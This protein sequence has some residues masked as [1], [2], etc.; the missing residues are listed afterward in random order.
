MGKAGRKELYVGVDVGGTKILAA[1][2]KHNGR[3]VARERIPT[4]LEAKPAVVVKAI[5]GAV[6]ALSAKAGVARSD[7][8][9]IG[10]AIPGVVDPDAGRVVIT[11]NMNL[12]GVRIVKAV[13]KR[14]DVPVALGN[15]VN[16]GTLGEKWL[17]AARQA[18]SVVGIF[19]GT[20]IGG[21]V[22]LDGRLHRGFRDSAGEVGHLIM[23]I[24]GPQCGCGARGCFE[25]IASRT[26]IER[27]IR[28]AIASRRR[29]LVSRLVDLND[30]SSLI[31][32]G[33]LRQALARKDK[34][35]LEVLHRAAE[36][37]GYA[38]LSIR[39]LIDPEVIVF[40]GGVIEACGYFLLPII[41]EIVTSDPLTGARPGGRIVESALADDAVA[42]GAAA[43]AQQMMGRN[44]FRRGRGKP[45][46]YP[47]IKPKGRNQVAIAAQTYSTSLYVRGDGKVRPW[48]RPARAAAGKAEQIDPDTLARVCTASP[49]VLFLARTKGR[50]VEPAPEAEPIL[51]YRQ[52]KLKVLPRAEAIAAYNACKATK[53]ILLPLG[54]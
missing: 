44:P 37:M 52:V 38:C 4:P 9:A 15:D 25:A 26:A 40:G 17:G 46:W 34:V 13:R 20:G 41:D 22:F 14:L 48:A 31:K 43:L 33:V 8:T 36:V 35:V 11:P 39:H 29:S 45:D 12:S 54:K 5:A 42:L 50:R 28:A 30:K 6:K 21:G 27:D 24:G 16:L 53:A 51:R 32:S 47:K 7:L 2:V 23:Q 10:L 3:V 1:L 18:E 49:S 19:V